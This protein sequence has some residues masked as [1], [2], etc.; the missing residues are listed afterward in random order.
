MKAFVGLPEPALSICD[1]TC[2]EVNGRPFPHVLHEQFIKPEHYRQLVESFPACPPTP[3]PTGYSLFWGDEGY[4]RLLDEHAAW[5]ALHGT[6]HQ[7][8]FIDWAAEQF[9]PIWRESGCAIDLSRARYVPYKEDRI[10]KARTSLRRVEHAPEELFVRMDIYQGRVGYGRS[11]HVDHRR[12]LVSMLIY[13]CDPMEGGELLLHTGA[14]QRWYGARPTRVAPRHN[15][16]VAFPCSSRSHHSVSPIVSQ[17]A[18]RNYIQVQ[19]SSSVD[20]WD[21]QGSADVESRSRSYPSTRAASA[22]QAREQLDLEASR[23]KL[24]GSL[25]GADD[26]TVIRSHGNIGDQLI[27]AGLR[28]L[29]RGFEYRE[30]G[31]EQ[32]YGARGRLAVVT[33]GGAW[34]APHQNL[35][36]YLPRIEKQFERVVIFPSSFDTRVKSVREALAATRALVFAREHTSFEQIRTL[37]RAEL[38]HDTAFFF[39]FEPYR[40]PG[41]GTLLAFRTDRESLTNSVPPGNLDLSVACESL[42]EFLW[43]IAR[44]EVVQTD[45]AHVMIAAALLGKEVRYAPSSYHKL[46]A[47]AASSLRDYK[48][49]PLDGY[50]FAATVEQA[51]APVEEIEHPSAPDAETRLLLDEFI[52]S[53]SFR[54]ISSYW[55]L[56]RRMRSRNSTRS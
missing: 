45:R 29:L 3:E 11:I 8:R 20:V 49:S 28:R 6:F 52:H 21:K 56:K 36:R 42:D 15:L 46:P 24:L 39:D 35:P 30:L 33:G 53:R 55:R 18:P 34:C 22:T 2:L 16:M 38:A 26:I 41:R 43:R 9:A 10:D 7:Q 31:L 1:L 32:L 17:D 37:C 19:I 48:V 51:L 50:E 23:T 25:E 4:Q 14:K 5:R 27:H 40:R 12:R 54:L 13:M 47:L 44:H